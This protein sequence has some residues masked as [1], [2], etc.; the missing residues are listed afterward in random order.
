M[1]EIKGLGG[2]P[3]VGQQVYFRKEDGTYVAVS[4]DNPLPF[5]LSESKIA[6][7]MDLQG[8]NMKNPGES[9]A[10][11]VVGGS[12]NGGG[13]NGVVTDFQTFVNK[14]V[15][16]DG[17]VKAIDMPDLSKYVRYNI[18]VLNG[19]DKAVKV[20]PWQGT[21]I[22]LEDGTFG[23]WEVTS[24]TTNKLNYSYL[25]PAKSAIGN[26]VFFLSELT[27]KS[28]DAGTIAAQ[29]S[30]GS[31]FTRVNTTGIGAMKLNY[32]AEGT[33]TTGDLTIR[34]VGYFK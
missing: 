7:P 29:K 14:V 32:R 8:S 9:V 33:P 13:D 20:A 22:V 12:V 16:R 2:N 10:V 23:A 21:H 6:L 4:E 5:V 24:D 30:S 19:L 18:Y 25:I 34:I 28:N 1:E 26:G 17:G 3:F 31:L 15:L 11:T 27:P